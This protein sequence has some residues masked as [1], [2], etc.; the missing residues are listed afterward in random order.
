M[1][2][3]SE[4]RR[5]HLFR[6]L[7]LAV[8]GIEAGFDC[9]A[10]TGRPAKKR[11][12]YLD[13]VSRGIDYLNQCWRE[14][15]HT[16]LDCV[17]SGKQWMLEAKLD[18]EKT[19]PLAEQLADRKFDVIRDNYADEIEGLRGRWRE[20]SRV[21][22]AVYERKQDWTAAQQTTDDLLAPPRDDEALTQPLT[23]SQIADAFK[24]SRHNVDRDILSKRWNNRVGKKYQ[25]KV[26]GMPASYRQIFGNTK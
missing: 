4:I 2:T 21:I 1:A 24:I 17:P 13:Q 8:R 26:S 18:A 6:T 7:Y 25:L 22:H 11:K 23:K 16:F 10:D 5:E 20:R 19:L 15:A 12:V 14:D 9:L 3:A